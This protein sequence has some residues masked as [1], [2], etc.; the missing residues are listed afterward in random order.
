MAF[1]V[2]LGIF[3]ARHQTLETGLKWW[4]CLEGEHSGNQVTSYSWD[5]QNIPPVPSDNAWDKC[6]EGL[7]SN[8]ISDNIYLTCM[9]MY[10]LTYVISTSR[11]IFNFSSVSSNVALS[12]SHQADR[13]SD[14]KAPWFSAGNPKIEQFCET[15]RGPHWASLSLVWC[16]L[17]CDAICPISWPG[18]MWSTIDYVYLH[19]T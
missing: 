8:L 9:I 14:E 12:F 3:W 10:D 19:F 16:I 5:W 7:F 11:E 18:E 6:F 15:Q 4:V 17:K 1:R 2:G 13:G